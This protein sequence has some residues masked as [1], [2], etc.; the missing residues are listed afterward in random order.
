[1]KLVGATDLTSYLRHF[2]VITCLIGSAILQHIKDGKIGVLYQNDD[3]GKDYFKGLQE[4]LGRSGESTVTRS[5]D[6]VADTV[7]RNKASCRRCRNRNTK[8]LRRD[9][10]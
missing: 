1:M 3:A 2:V 9:W 6:I 7:F 4:D 8:E 10:W 5:S